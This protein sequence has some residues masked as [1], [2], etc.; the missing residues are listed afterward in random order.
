[1]NLHEENADQMDEITGLPVPD[2]PALEHSERLVQ[3]IRREIERHDGH[4]GFD[5]FMQMALYEP[6]LGYYS[7]GSR[8]FGGQGDFVTAPEI[9]PLYSFCL[10]RQCRQVLDNLTD[11]SILELGAGSGRMAC[12]ILRELQRSD[13]LPARYLIL[14][15]SA[16][17]RQRQRQLLQEVLPGYFNRIEWLD[18]LPAEPLS[19]VILANEVMDAL[20]VHRVVMRDDQ[21]NEL[22]VACL[23]ATFSW[24]E[25]T[26]GSQL[27]KQ[28][29]HIRQQLPY[30]WHDGYTTEL[31]TTVT[32]WITT[33]ADVLQSGVMLLIDYGYTRKEF[34]HPQRADGT[35][36]CHYRHRVH[37]N[38]FI[39]PGL[40]DITASVDFTAIAETAAAAGLTVAGF[41]TQGYFLVGCGL[42]EMIASADNHDQRRS[43]ELANQVKTLTLPGEMGERF[44]VIGLTRN[45]ES[46]LMGFTPMDHRRHL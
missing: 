5:R 32:A 12:D 1:M 11:G 3:G 15:T 18:R 22:H 30:A 17:L 34:Y 39:Y 41:T 19:G 25:V 42:E 33:L 24:T 16:D 38:P 2:A 45:I 7:A 6:G 8:K 20:P 36:L 46:D 21:L 23:D 35:L 10:A 37:T 31:N 26:A 14:E 44:K 28:M 43:L 40:Q 13:S 9:S 27:I 4:I 29:Q